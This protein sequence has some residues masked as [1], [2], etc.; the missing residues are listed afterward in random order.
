[1]NMNTETTNAISQYMTEVGQ[2]ARAASRLIGRAETRVKDA[3]LLA[4]AVR[5]KPL[6][7]G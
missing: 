4:I 3:A 2:R 1:M 6:R 7:S 5:W